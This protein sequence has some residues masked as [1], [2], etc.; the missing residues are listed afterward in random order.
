MIT[1][2]A[3]AD[4]FDSHRLNFYILKIRGE[5]PYWC[6]LVYKPHESYSIV[7]SPTKH[8]A[9]QVMRVSY[10]LWTSPCTTWLVIA[11]RKASTVCSSPLSTYKEAN[12]LN[13]IWDF[14]KTCENEVPIG[15]SK[16]IFI[17]YH[18]VLIELQSLKVFD[19][20]YPKFRRQT[21]CGEDLRESPRPGAPQRGAQHW[22]GR[23]ILT[24]GKSSLLLVKSC[25]WYPLVI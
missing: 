25:K 1:M 21:P 16:F 14:V 13:K 8:I 15:T 22:A 2:R 18:D 23:R 7:M 10:R 3:S 5:A 6:L 4:R 11:A 12:M 20:L 19:T 9:R 17:F 24:V